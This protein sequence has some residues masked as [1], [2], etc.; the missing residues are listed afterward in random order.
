MYAGIQFRFHFCLID[1]VHNVAT[2][3]VVFLRNNQVCQSTPKLTSFRQNIEIHNC[4][5]YLP[6]LTIRGG[7]VRLEARIMESTVCAI[8]QV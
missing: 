6:K 7:L 8:R 4:S 2:Y 5:T 3:V 1:S